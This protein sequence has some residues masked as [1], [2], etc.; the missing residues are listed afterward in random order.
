MNH[1]NLK[2]MILQK[3]YRQILHVLQA[4]LIL[5]FDSKVISAVNLQ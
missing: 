5:T 1:L 2:M 4:L 3:K